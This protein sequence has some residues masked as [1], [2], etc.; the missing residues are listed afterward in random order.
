MCK[1][2]YLHVQQNGNTT[3][4]SLRKLIMN[5]I[6]SML[7]ITNDF[8]FLV[9][10]MYSCFFYGL[11]DQCGESALRSV[12][13]NLAVALVAVRAVASPG[14]WIVTLR[15]LVSLAEPSSTNS[16]ESSSECMN[17]TTMEFLETQVSVG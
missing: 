2:C 4:R 12:S 11:T 9:W 7:E 6:M 14:V 13:P 15:P 1:Y 17:F 8:Y 5:L 16:T 3:R 10:I